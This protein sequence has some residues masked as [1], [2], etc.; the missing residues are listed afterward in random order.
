MNSFLRKSHIPHSIRPLRRPRKEVAAPWLPFKKR[1]QFL[2]T[3]VCCSLPAEIIA[4]VAQ[5][6]GDTAS[7]VATEGIK[8]FR[9]KKKKKFLHQLFSGLYSSSPVARPLPAVETAAVPFVT[10]QEVHFTMAFFF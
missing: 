5:H 1:Q 3:L 8:F 2:A 6:R 4:G 10:S 9:L 7:A